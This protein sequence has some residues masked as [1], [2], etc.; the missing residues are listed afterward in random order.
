MSRFDEKLESRTDRFLDLGPDVE[1]HSSYGP[2]TIIGQ[3]RYKG[4]EVDG[5]KGVLPI[6]D[7]VKID[8]DL[9]VG[10]VFMEGKAALVDLYEGTLLTDFDYDDVEFSAADHS[11]ILKKE[12]RKGLFDVQTRNVV[13]DTAYHEINRNVGQRFSWSYSPEAGYEINDSL[14]DRTIQLGKGVEECF[15]EKY[16]HI[17]V[18]RDGRIQMIDDEG[19]SDAKGYRS[20]L[21]SLGGRLDLYNSVKGILVTA[22]IYAHI[23]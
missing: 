6:Y 18:L 14:K 12:G 11:V 7:D 22:D 1:R 3:R 4:V 2:F 23:I 17:F 10:A 20:L 21:A 13:M 15:D 16:G 9:N 8:G 5:A 19:Y